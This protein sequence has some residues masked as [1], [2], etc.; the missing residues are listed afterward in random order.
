[1]TQARVRNTRRWSTLLSLGLT[2]LL[3]VAGAAGQ[4]VVQIRPLGDTSEAAT[5]LMARARMLEAERRW[6][7]AGAT[8]RQA[9]SMELTVADRE[10]AYRHLAAIAYAQYQVQRLQNSL[11]AALSSGGSIGDRE[12]GHIGMSSLLDT[13]RGFGGFG[14]FAAPAALSMEITPRY[15]RNSLDTD[16]PQ[17]LIIV[18]SETEV[19]RPHKVV[20]EVLDASE[21]D[22]VELSYASDGPDTAA[23]ILMRHERG[24]RWVATIPADATSRAGELQVWVSAVDTLGNASVERASTSVR[25][26]GRGRLRYIVGAAGLGAA[27]FAVSL[28]RGS[29]SA[30]GVAGPPVFSPAPLPPQ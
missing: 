8:L 2:A 22:R 30:A 19:G 10:D 11:G 27:A 5:S 14:G 7:E 12:L 6:D 15:A 1:M 21:V 24:N 16:G 20:A 9:L 28:L 29:P 4:E 25:K 3:G 26:S 13:G 18:A 17:V 23:T